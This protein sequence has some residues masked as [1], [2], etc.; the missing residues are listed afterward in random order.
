VKPYREASEV[1]YVLVFLRRRGRDLRAASG[2]DKKE[3]LPDV[4]LLIVQ[5]PRN[6]GQLANIRRHDRGVDL[7]RKSLRAKSL[8]RTNRRIE[9]PV[10]SPNRVVRRGSGAVQAK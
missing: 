8:N 7:G 5:Q 4:H 2:G 1:A 10:D 9:M 6:V 3:H